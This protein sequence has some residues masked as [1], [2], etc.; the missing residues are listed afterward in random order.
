MTRLVG[1]STE[2]H[3]PPLA[4]AQALALIAVLENALRR[5][6]DTYGDDVIPLI[7]AGH[8]PEADDPPTDLRDDLPF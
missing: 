1:K 8:P 6:W 5:L 4:P 3:L 2:L 7:I